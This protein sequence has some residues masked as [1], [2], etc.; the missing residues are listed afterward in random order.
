MKPSQQST[1]GNCSSFPP[2]CLNTC[3]YH[4][5]RSSSSSLLHL[6]QAEQS[7][8]SA[9]LY[10]THGSSPSLFVWPV[11]IFLIQGSLDLGT[12][13]RQISQAPSSTERSL[14][15]ILGLLAFFHINACSPVMVMLAS[16]RNPWSF[17]QF[18]C[19]LQGCITESIT[20][21]RYC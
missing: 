19:D 12:A 3:L 1:T 7:Q 15:P 10:L 18:L 8:L 16:P 6:L 2:C 5:M 13:P 14:L 11:Y 20:Q 21:Q 9:T 4:Q 17:V